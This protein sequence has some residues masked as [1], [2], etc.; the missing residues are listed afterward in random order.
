MKQ[1]KTLQTFLAATC[2]TIASLSYANT[3]VSMNFT[4][5]EGTGAPAGTI[6]VT[7]TPFGLLFTPNLHGLTPGAHGLH[8]HE[9]AS[10]DKDG[11]SAG[12]HYDPKHTG[13]HLGPYNNDG[14]LGD[15]P[16]LYVNTDGS[17]TTPVLAPRLRYIADISQH[18]LM[19]HHSG[20]NYADNPDKLGGGGTRMVC[21]ILNGATQ[22]N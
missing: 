9:F 20:D 13:Q 21:G 2:L 8:I 7:E 5:A 1:L 3:S 4:A 12:S 18:A 10:C 17:A 15:L 22:S 19:V 11:M 6:V 14:H 16:I